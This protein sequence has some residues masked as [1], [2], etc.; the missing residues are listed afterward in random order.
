MGW[1]ARPDAVARRQNLQEL[2]PPAQSIVVVA[3]S[4]RTHEPWD[5]AEMGKIARYARGTDYH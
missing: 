5:E 2:W 3:M 4:Y 1:M